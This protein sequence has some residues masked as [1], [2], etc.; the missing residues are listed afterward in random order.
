MTGASI[1]KR[2]LDAF[3]SGSY[4]LLALLRLLDITET[5]EVDTA[6]VE[7]TAMPRLL[8]NAAFVEAHA[9][10]PE[11][12][13]MLIMHELHHVLLGHTR[14]FPRH[15]DADNLIF[16][17]V[18]NALLCRMF[19]SPEHTSFFTEFYSDKRFP[20]CLLRPP[21]RWKPALAARIPPAL[22]GPKMRRV[23]EVYRAL[24][25]ETGASYKELYD[26]LRGA[27]SRAQGVFLI[28]SH[29][30]ELPELESVVFETVRSIVENWPQPPDPIHGR[31][32]S[33]LLQL[34]SVRP[35]RG[36]RSI[37]RGLIR[38]VAGPESKALS[39][40][41]GSGQAPAL[42]P[43]PSGDRRSIVLRALGTPQ[44]IYRAETMGRARERCDRVHVYLDVSGS[45][46]CFQ[47]SLYGAVLD[48][49]DVVHPTV[50]LFSDSVHDVS[51]NGLRGGECRTTG[52][53]SIECVA[54]H[55]RD[56]RVRRAVLLTDGWVGRPGP[57]SAQSLGAVRLGVALTPASNRND[58]EPYVRHWAE[59]DLEG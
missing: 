5:S 47:S 23:Q 32:M 35:R 31:S 43:I 21:S 34:R 3:P 50:H 6:A 18:I 4:G 26:S 37:L 17:A 42:M 48:C 16:D 52:G 14:L 54:A 40:F 59:L 56:H 2:I 20:E 22:E 39:R 33:E 58:L 38:K 41:Y 15:T 19:P 10:T 7:C 46:S 24:Y 25:S 28:G 49:N 29:G 12:L 53:T 11:R 51:L 27:L 30:A 36:N 13:L 57:G 8:V 1:A 9:A 44:L 45:T 55:M